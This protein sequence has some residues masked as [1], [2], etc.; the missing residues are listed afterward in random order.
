MTCEQAF[1]LSDATAERSA[2]GCTIALD[3]AP[4]I[5]YLQSNI[6]LLEWMIDQ[7]YEDKRT[8][9]R[10][11][12]SMKT[13][14]KN[15]TLMKADE[16]ATYK[17]ILDIDLNDIKEPILCAPN[18]P[19]HAVLLSEVQGEKVDEVF[20]G[21]CMTNIGHFRVAGE[22]LRRETRPLNTTLWISP[23][24]KMDKHILQEEG[25]YDVYKA[26][27]VQIEMPGCSLCMG[28][29]A[30]VKDNATVL[31]TSTRNFP[32]RLG[33][34]ANVYLSSAELSAITAMEGTIPT[35]DT[36]LNTMSSLKDKEESIFT[37]MNFHQNTLLK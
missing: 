32:N 16:G 25:Y 11:I 6:A 1:E 30:R 14:L 31:S 23:P 4:V 33:K 17:E 28:N 35:L 22:L 3:E 20:I 34:G 8:I 19:D 26:S 5:E 21:S 12:E 24:T 36:Y 9:A 15:P 7:N 2:A 27:N 10:R 37:Y 29:Q 18:D 13:W